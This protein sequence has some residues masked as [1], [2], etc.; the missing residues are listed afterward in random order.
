M[1]FVPAIANG[2]AGLMSGADKA[3]L[4]A[5]PSAYLR[6]IWLQDAVSKCGFTN[7]V[8]YWRDMMEDLSDAADGGAPGTQAFDATLGGVLNL[9]SSTTSSTVIGRIFGYN[10][11]TSFAPFPAG[12]TKGF[13][14]AMR[15]K[16]P[17]AVDGQTI[18][19]LYGSRGASGP[20]LGVNGSV[21]TT[22]FSAA[23]FQNG[24]NLVSTV[25]ID[26][27]WHNLVLYRPEGGSLTYLSVDGETPVS[28]NSYQDA[29]S[30]LAVYAQNGATAANRQLLVDCITCIAQRYTA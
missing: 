29:A 15:C 22:K 25:N 13:Y 12:A 27:N 1:F 11:N 20:R 21:S 23:N 14:L 10:L 7:P 9:Q 26:T 3:K 30:P 5:I 17:T 4:D 18:L 8:D 2:A 19:A 16:V 6:S 28:A 24:G